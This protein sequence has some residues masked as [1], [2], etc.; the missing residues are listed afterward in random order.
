[1]GLQIVDISHSNKNTD[2][3]QNQDPNC[4]Q[5]ENYVHGCQVHTR[6]KAVSDSNMAVFY[7]S[8]KWV[9]S[10]MVGYMSGPNRAKIWAYYRNIISIL[11]LY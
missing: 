9:I 2:N 1:M 6:L 10:D 11:L 5:T 4:D 8:Y 7:R 3:L